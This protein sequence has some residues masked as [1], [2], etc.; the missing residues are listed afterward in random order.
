MAMDPRRDGL[1]PTRAS[2]RADVRVVERPASARCLFQEEWWLEA[3]S[4]GAWER[5]EA[6]HAS[7]AHAVLPFVRERVHGVLRIG[8]PP[9]TR[10]LGPVFTLPPSKPVTRAE[11]MRALVGELA[12]RLPRHDLFEQ[13]LAPGAEH[14]ALA[15]VLNGFAARTQ[16]TFRIAPDVPPERSWDALCQKTR[17]LVRTASRRFRVDRHAEIGR[18]VALSRAQIAAGG[19]ADRHRYAAMARAFDAAQ[20]RGQAAV[21]SAMED[22]RQAASVALVWDGEAAYL[23]NTARDPGLAGSGALSLLVWEA[24]RLAAARGLAMDMDAFGT[25]AAG[26]FVAAFGG[27]PVPRPVIVRRGILSSAVTFAGDLLRCGR[28]L[29]RRASEA[30]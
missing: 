2:G 20:A 9:Y 13:M 21:L 22:D 26:R 19:K 28:G 4:G 5:V 25:P 10:T 16:Y 17:N 11:N 3:A 23:W 8:M 6:G 14:A 27:E 29:L 24:C 30:A 12:G 15:F 1:V 7:G 18:F